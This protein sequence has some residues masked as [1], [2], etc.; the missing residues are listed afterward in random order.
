MV[1]L[2]EKTSEVIADKVFGKAIE[3]YGEKLRRNVLVVTKFEN[4]AEVIVSTN[5]ARK[6]EKR[7]ELAKALQELFESGN[8]GQE[9]DDYSLVSNRSIHF[10]KL[11][12]S[13]KDIKRGWNNDV[14][15]D[16]TTLY[17]NILGYGKGGS[18]S[19]VDTKFKKAEKPKWW[20]DANNFEKYSH[21]SKAKMR[22][23]QDIIEHI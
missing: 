8:D 3:D 15:I 5:I 16:Q 12:A 17:L 1:T 9:E 21:P 14:V 18:K 6:L 4:R 11:L 23:N 10:P 22:V 19:L 20:D 7:P 13:F 2:K